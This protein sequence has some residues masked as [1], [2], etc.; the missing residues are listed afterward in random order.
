MT[1]NRFRTLSGIVAVVV[2]AVLIAKTEER[3]PILSFSLIAAGAIG[4]LIDRL[5]F[6]EVVDFIDW[7]VKSW[8]WPAFNVADSAITVGVV[9][10]AIDMLVRRNPKHE[11]LKPK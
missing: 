10:L 8:H 6:G 4:N 11:S 7:Y 9:L 1:K 3:M 5:R 2:I